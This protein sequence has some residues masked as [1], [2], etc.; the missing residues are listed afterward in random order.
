MSKMTKHLY[1]PKEKELTGDVMELNM[2]P[3]HPS[4]HGVLRLKL[5]LDG[6]VVLSAEPIIGYLHTGVEKECESR[7]YQQ[8]FKLVN[9]LDYLSGPAEEEAYA[10]SVERLMQIEVPERAQTIRLILLE[11]SRIAS[12]LLWLGTSAVELNMSS[13]FMYCF[14]ER[15]K[16]LDLLEE[17]SGARMF[18][19]CWR[20][21]G[22]SNDL[23]P[24]FEEHARLFLKDFPKTWK[25]LDNLLTH[26]YV[27]CER[28]QGVAVMNK[29]LCEQYMCT[30]PVIRAAGVPYDIRKVYPYLGYENY[31]FD[32]PVRDEGDAYARYL[33]RMEEM[34]QSASLVEQALTKLKPGPVLTDNR[35]V[36]LPP[37]SELPRSMEAVIHQFKLVSEGIHPPIGELYHCVESARGEL[38]YYLVSD[39]SNRPYRVGVR[40]PSFSPLQ[41]L[42]RALP[43]LI[44]SDV[45]VAIA[46]VDPILGDV[47]R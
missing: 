28:L 14:A 29:E 42:K 5:R 38:G 44:L 12:H 4:T 34:K 15:E 27:W 1:N 18:P 30:G 10:A 3:Q 22:V 24:G 33:V 9:R 37:R 47:D 39:G 41:A 40:S 23:N 7:T 36:A 46:S 11:L 25:D 13:V 2:G 19:S 6:E 21:G 17:Y 43:G 31:Q 20:F 35:K 32:I 26:N 8:V 45:V 16:I